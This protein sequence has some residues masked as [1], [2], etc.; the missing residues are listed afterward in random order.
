ME[1][2]PQPTKN[3]QPGMR[4]LLSSVAKPTAT[5]AAHHPVESA[6]SVAAGTRSSSRVVL[7]LAAGSHSRT[8]ATH[9]GSK[10][11]KMATFPQGKKE[12]F[13]DS[14]KGARS[15]EDQDTA[16]HKADGG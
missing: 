15:M 14:R 4:L 12:A 3:G 10:T 16:E 13:Q 11:E 1:T 2:T 8:T 7:G 5:Y 6:I 9:S